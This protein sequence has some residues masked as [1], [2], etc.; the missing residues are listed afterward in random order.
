MDLCPEA[1][2]FGVRKMVPSGPVVYGGCKALMAFDMPPFPV[3]WRLGYQS[4]NIFKEIVIWLVGFKLQPELA[5][6]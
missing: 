5:H 4:L 2:R 1:F 6:L 3:Q